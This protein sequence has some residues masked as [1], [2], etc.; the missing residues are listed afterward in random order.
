MFHKNTTLSMFH[1]AEPL[2]P[3]VPSLS[4]GTAYCEEKP[5]CCIPGL[6]Y[7]KLYRPSAGHHEIDLLKCYFLVITILGDSTILGT[8]PWY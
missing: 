2:P 6:D 1:L 8:T 4:I 5:Y 7:V 3:T